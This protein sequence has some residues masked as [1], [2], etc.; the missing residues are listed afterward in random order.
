M[1]QHGQGITGVDGQRHPVLDMQRRSPTAESAA[2][3]DVVVHQEG[4]VQQLDGDGRQHRFFAL[5]AKGG[6]RGQAEAG[7]YGLAASPGVV[8]DQVVEPGLGLVVGKV[9]GRGFGDH[10][11]IASQV[12][13]DVGVGE[14][15]SSGTSTRSG[16]DTSGTPVARM[17][18]W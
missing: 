18:P 17:C 14:G 9:T 2:I 1:G 10:G 8:G 11:P 3:F 4:V 6:A 12:G 16:S 15:H 13:L 7:P 5:A